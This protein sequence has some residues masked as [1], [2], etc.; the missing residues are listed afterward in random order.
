MARHRAPQKYASIHSPPVCFINGPEEKAPRTPRTTSSRSPAHGSRRM[1]HRSCQHI[2]DPGAA[3][4][5]TIKKSVRLGA[6]CGFQ[7]QHK[8]RT[9]PPATPFEDQQARTSRSG[10]RFFIISRTT[11]VASWR[12]SRWHGGLR[13]P[14]KAAVRG[15]WQRP[16]GAQS[17]G[18]LNPQRVF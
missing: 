12:S 10:T 8:R 1:S 9:S 5:A 11:P 6:G 16:S 17:Q 3:T 2:G 4:H 15:L 13:I 14:S 7:G 18:R